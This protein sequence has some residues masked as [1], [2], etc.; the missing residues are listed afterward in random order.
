MRDVAC[1]LLVEAGER[2][3]FVV[4]TLEN[5]VELRDNEEI[6]HWPGHEHELYL[7]AMAG[8]CTVAPHD[9]TQPSGVDVVAATH[10]QQDLF[11]L[12]VEQA[13]D[14]VFQ[15][16]IAFTESDSALNVQDGHVADGAFINVHVVSLAQ[17]GQIRTN[18]QKAYNSVRPLSIK[19][20]YL[21]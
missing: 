9:F 17:N 6:P 3:G 10:I 2:L 18:S 20:Y 12:L 7:T 16:L 1:A 13:V 11:L 5:A 21:V 4:E 8:Q 15:E 19:N 14:L